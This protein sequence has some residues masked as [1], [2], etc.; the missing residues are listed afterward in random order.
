MPSNLEEKL[1]VNE[2]SYRWSKFG[3]IKG[4]N[5]KY[6]SGSSRPGDYYKLF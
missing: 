2:Q 5:V 1:V 4:E 6:N 3:D